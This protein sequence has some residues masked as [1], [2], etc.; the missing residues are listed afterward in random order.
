M[1]VGILPFVKKKCLRRE[2]DDVVCKLQINLDW[3]GTKVFQTVSSIITWKEAVY[4]L[5]IK[6]D[7]ISSGCILFR[8]GAADYV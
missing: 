2:T 1:V 4:N 3:E 8:Q 5:F 6:D 7:C